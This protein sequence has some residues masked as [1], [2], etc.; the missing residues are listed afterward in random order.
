[1]NAYVSSQ[2]TKTNP[3]IFFLEGEA[4][5][6]PGLRSAHCRACGK[7]TMGRVP[8]CS[9]CFSRDIEV[10]AAGQEAVLVEH[11][12]AHHPAGGFE[13]P[14]AIGQIRTSEGLIL[15]APLM[16]ETEGLAPGDKLFFIA[17]E[18]GNGSVGFAYE[19]RSAAGARA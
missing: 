3:H 4:P 10:V 14:Y 1:M 2:R 7:S 16:G 5:G 12:V 13:A 15:F 8:A 9:H 6:A 11:S 18:R 19:S 17:V